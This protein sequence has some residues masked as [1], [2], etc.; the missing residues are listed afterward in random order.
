MSKITKE[1]IAQFKQQR[2]DMIAQHG[3]MI[4][5]VG[6]GEGEPSFSYTIG[7]T[8]KNLPEL[9]T[10]GL[11]LQVAHSI[12]NELARRSSIGQSIEGEHTNLA[13]MPLRVRVVESL[14]I[15]E[16][17]YAMGVSDVYPTHH[18]QYLQLVWPDTEGRFPGESGYDSERF[19]QPML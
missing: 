11:P 17:K 3:W 5:G 12:L 10:I 2:L 1:Q 7:L 4:Q 18:R 9:I 19:R 8:E 6:A 15:I 13:N 16:T 14:K